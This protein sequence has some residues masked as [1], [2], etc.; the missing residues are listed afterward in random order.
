[1][2]IQTDMPSTKD[3]ISSLL[4]RLKSNE[5]L[6]IV[7]GTPGRSVDEVFDGMKNRLKELYSAQN[8]V[9]MKE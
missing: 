4:S 3:E 2:I 8:D 1:M 5:D 7:L 9:P 6:Q